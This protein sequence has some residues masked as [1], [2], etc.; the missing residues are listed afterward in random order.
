MNCRSSTAWEILS[1]F[2]LAKS[3][4]I[5]LA[6]PLVAAGE[7]PWFA[8]PTSAKEYQSRAE[9]LVEEGK[10]DAAIEDFTE[11]IRLDPK[12]GVAYISRGVVLGLKG[13]YTTS[14]QDLT[15]AIRLNPMDSSAYMNRGAMLA[16]KGDQAA[17]VK[18]LTESIRLNPYHSRTYNIRGHVFNH[19]KDYDAAIQDFSEAIRINPNYVVAYGGRATAYFWHGKYESAIKDFTKAISLDPQD[20]ISVGSL[21]WFFATCPD[22]KYRDGKRAVELATKAC[23]LTNWK[24]YD[25][26]NILAA[27]CAETGDW[28]NAVKR[29]EQAIEMARNARDKQNGEQQVVHSKE[30]LALYAQKKPYREK[31][32]EAKTASRE[33]TPPAN[34]KK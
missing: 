21:A 1:M 9:T 10:L 16:A 11:A 22:G 32:V 14:I 8:K 3:V 28:E 4:C 13:Q 17:A 27:A 30:R 24:V 20:P 19:N 23:E 18:D 26:L 25:P 29:Q 6:F 31:P 15:E 5:L 34:R 7:D 33:A 2:R 12:N